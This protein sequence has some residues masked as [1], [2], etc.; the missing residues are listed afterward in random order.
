MNPLHR[1]LQEEWAGA[2]LDPRMAC[3]PAVRAWNGS[4]PQRRFDV[5]RNNVASSLIGALADT[6]PVVQAL[7]G[8]EFFRAMAGVFVRRHPPL[9]PLLARYGEGFPEFVETFEP[10]RGLPYLPDVARLELARLQALHAAD[11]T[12]IDARAL[13]ALLGAGERVGEL[14][15]ALHPSLR[16]LASGFAVVSIWAAHQGQ[17]DL[18]EVAVRR[19]ESAVVVRPHLDVLVVPCDPGTVEFVLGLQRGCDFAESAGRAAAAPGGCDLAATLRLLVGHGAITSM[20]GHEERW[21]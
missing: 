7:V 6:F 20:Q 11:A 1:S 12:S 10:A 13:A 2:L 9:S 16:L 19:G 8:E 3:P 5:Y 15:L 21:Q 18:A 17:G 14:R 4:D